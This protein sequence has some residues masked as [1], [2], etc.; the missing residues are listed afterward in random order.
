MY[1][2]VVCNQSF[3]IYSL[4]MLQSTIA[5]SKL[6][7]TLIDQ[8]VSDAHLRRSLATIATFVSQDAK[9]QVKVQL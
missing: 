7:S 6:V 8:G 5:V 4:L 2:L 9:V 3:Y 1:I